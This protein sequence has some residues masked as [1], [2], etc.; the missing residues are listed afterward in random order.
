MDGGRT[1]GDRMLFS[2]TANTARTV[3]EK[4][5]EYNAHS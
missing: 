3:V 2:G 1:E 5:C 4:L